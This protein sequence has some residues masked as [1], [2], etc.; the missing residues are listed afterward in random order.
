MATASGVSP[1]RHASGLAPVHEASTMDAVNLLD[2]PDDYK[3]YASIIQEA[4]K[5]LP[6]EPPTERTNVV[7]TAYLERFRNVAIQL[8]LTED[9]AGWGLPIYP[10]P[11]RGVLSQEG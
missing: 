6:S 1:G 4:L 10:R 8:R 3:L 7:F 2:G 11:I 5:D 9:E